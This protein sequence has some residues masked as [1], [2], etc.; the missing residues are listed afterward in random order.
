MYRSVINGVVCVCVEKGT[1]GAVLHE[2][3][4]WMPERA[5]HKQVWSGADITVSNGCR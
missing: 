1:Q 2:G 4:S 5:Y 3:L